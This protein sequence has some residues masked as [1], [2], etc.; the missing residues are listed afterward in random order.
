MSMEK[1]KEELK[2]R[3]LKARALSN[4]ELEQVTGGVVGQVCTIH[5]GVL[6]VNGVCPVC[7]ELSQQ[8]QQPFMPNSCPTCGRILIGGHCAKCG[9]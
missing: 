3:L 2:E 6:L 5:T 8:S 9:Y 4:D 7:Y 1:N